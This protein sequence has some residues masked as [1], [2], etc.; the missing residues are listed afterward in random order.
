MYNNKMYKYGSNRSAIRDLFEYGKQRKQEIGTLNV[1]DFSLGNPSVPAPNVV[2]ETLIKLLQEKDSCMLHGYTSAQGDLEVRNS[3]MNYLNSTYNAFVSSDLMYLTV[4]AAASLT[5]SLNAILNEGDEVIVI[6]PFFPEYVVFIEKAGGKAIIV[7]SDEKFLP[8]LEELK[9]AITKKTKASGLEELWD[10][11]LEE[12]KNLQTDGIIFTNFVDFDMNWG[13]RRDIKGYA[14]GLMY[15]DSRLPEIESLLAPDD[16]VIITA[17]HG[18]DPTYKG[19]DHTRECVPVIMF[20]KNITTQ[21]IGCR[22]TY[23][24][25]AQT[26]ARIFKLEPFNIGT[27]F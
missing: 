1:Y 8:N 27:A 4:G 21:N 24:D 15:F 17:D 26:I 12:I 25:I 5:I 10:K 6:A 7:N 16:V 19:T 23:A 2:N 22:K 13:H 3:I 20:G 9:I 18:C 11:T 14:E